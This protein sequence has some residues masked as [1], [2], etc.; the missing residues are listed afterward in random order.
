MGDMGD[1]KLDLRA[2]NGDDGFQAAAS[3]ELGVVGSKRSCCCCCCGASETDA[4]ACASPSASTV[5]HASCLC[6][7]SGSNSPSSIAGC[8]FG[9]RFAAACSSSALTSL[10]KD[11][12]H[13]ASSVA[14]G[15]HAATAPNTWATTSTSVTTLAWSS[16]SACSRMRSALDS[17]RKHSVRA[18]LVTLR[19]SSDAPPDGADPALAPGPH[20]PASIIARAH[21]KCCSAATVSPTASASSPALMLHRSACSATGDGDTASPP[22][23]LSQDT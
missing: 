10:P 13:R 1:W 17:S 3:S 11:R 5:R 4:V 20:T 2:V 8:W 9:A 21:R 7:A 23:P 16:T 19:A 22:L 12:R 14:S 6:A 18:R 15:P